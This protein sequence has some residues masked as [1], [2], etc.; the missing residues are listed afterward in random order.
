[1]VAID[2]IIMAGEDA[3]V[4]AKDKDKEKTLKEA[5]AAIHIHRIEYGCLQY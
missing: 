3:T 5:S 4:I 1:M 2:I